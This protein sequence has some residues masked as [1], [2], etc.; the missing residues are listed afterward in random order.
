ME[1]DNGR[2]ASQSQWS[3]ATAAFGRVESC[4]VQ[5]R[6]T[7]MLGPRYAR[8]RG[9][10]EESSRRA[11]RRL[12]RLRPPGRCTPEREA[13]ARRDP[14]GAFAA[15]SRAPSVQG[16]SGGGIHGLHAGKGKLAHEKTEVRK[17]KKNN[18]AAVARPTQ[19]RRAAHPAIN[20]GPAGRPSRYPAGQ[21]KQLPVP[22]PRKQR[23]RE[24]NQSCSLMCTCLHSAEF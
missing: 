7:W 13:P 19:L 24:K 4:I 14:A 10:A 6:Q 15:P 22:P 2:G 23:K 9:L 16:S 20:V 11:P 8:A 3:F 5:N 12:P 1:K 21:W 17:K 18:T